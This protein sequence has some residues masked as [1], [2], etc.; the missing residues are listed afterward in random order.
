MKKYSWIILVFLLLGLVIGGAVAILQPPAYL[1]NSTLLVTSMPTYGGST[2]GMQTIAPISTTLKTSAVDESIT[3][4]GEILTRAV[5]NY[6]FKIYPQL[7][8]HGLK[9]DEL[10]V[11]VTDTNPTPNVAT[12][13][14]TASAPRRSTALMI[15]NDVANGYVA[16]KNEHAQNALDANR[17]NL[18]NLYNQYQAQSTQL[19]NQILTYN[20]TT[21]PH[22][23]QLMD[24][25][26]GVLKSMQ[27]VQAQL[28]LLP[29]SV[30]GNVYVI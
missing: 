8:A 6:V 2:T 14:L 4:T 9:P 10:L 17:S 19:Y 13:L 12:I 16:Y 1:V 30:H 21:D 27:A 20:N 23:L 11:S 7:R 22:I 18:Q 5:M 28:I 29:A 24:E 25:R 15:A 26:N 3:D